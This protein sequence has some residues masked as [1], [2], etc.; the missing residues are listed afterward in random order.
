M[1]YTVRDLI[2]D[3]CKNIIRDAKDGELTFDRIK[4]RI[5]RFA[6]IVEADL[7]EEL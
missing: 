3:M 5:L 4:D 1:P 2:D 7:D 6:E